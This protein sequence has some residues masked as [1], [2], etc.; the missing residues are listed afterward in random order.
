MFSSNQ[1]FQISGGMRQLEEALRFALSFSEKSHSKI[2][3]QTTDDGKYCIGWKGDSDIKGWEQ[4]PFDF[5][6]SIVAK[7]IIQYLQK[8]EYAVS[9]YESFDGGAEQGFIMRNI[10]ETFSDEYQGIKNPFYGIVSFEKFC[11]F[12]SK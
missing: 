12:Y 11:N 8:Q 10:P 1:V 9:G 7:I 3:F 4:Y 6:A 5:D 2:V